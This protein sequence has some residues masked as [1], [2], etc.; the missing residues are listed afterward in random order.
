MAFVSNSEKKVHECKLCGGEIDE[1]KKIHWTQGHNADCTLARVIGLEPGSRCCSHCNIAVVASRIFNYKTVGENK[2]MLE[3]IAANA[4][5]V[6][7]GIIQKI[8]D[9]HFANKSDDACLECGADTAPGSGHFVGRVP[10]SRFDEG[11]GRYVTGHVCSEC[12]QLDCDR[13]SKPIDLDC[14]ITTCDVYDEGH[15][16]YGKEFKD[17]CERICEYCLTDEERPLWESK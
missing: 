12:M 3:D 14:D 9:K 6:S 4:E 13:C 7:A 16:R 11:L 10:G 5:L 2:A 17:G 1:I 8:V 15:D